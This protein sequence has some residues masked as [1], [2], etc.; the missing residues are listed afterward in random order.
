MEA[1]V[2]AMEAKVAA[3]AL[4]SLMVK[5]CIKKTLAQQTWVSDC[6]RVVGFVRQLMATMMQTTV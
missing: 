6:A 3:L 2:I 5:I 4:P 1:K